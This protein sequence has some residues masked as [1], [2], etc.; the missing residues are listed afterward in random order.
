M[1]KGWADWAYGASKLGVT[2]LTKIQGQEVS[3]DSS[4]KDVLINCVSSPTSSIICSSL[5]TR[6]SVGIPHAANSCNRA[7]V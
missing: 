7:D 6:K 2:T 3:K 4:K 1:K 5:H